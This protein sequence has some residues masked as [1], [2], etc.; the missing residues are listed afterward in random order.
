[1]FSYE[2]TEQYCSALDEKIRK[3]WDGAAAAKEGEIYPWHPYPLTRAKKIW[4]DYM[5]LGF[6]RDE[7]G[8]ENMAEAIIDKIITLHA[9]TILS[10]HTPSS[11]ENIL[12]DQGIAWDESIYDKFCDWSVDKNGQDILS[13]YGLEPL[14]ILAGKIMEAS[15]AEE[16]LLLIDQVLNV[17][18][19]R[20][21][22]ASMFIRGGRWA[23]DELSNQES[24]VERS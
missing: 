11:P 5:T 23:L 12:E 13:D 18:H 10:R 8:L 22:L 7:K 1:M 9:M 2:T 3:I 17:V 24:L 19:Q 21:D 20:S 16:K 14:Q 6:V 15:T 4:Q